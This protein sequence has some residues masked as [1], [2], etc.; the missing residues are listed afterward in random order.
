MGAMGGEVQGRS[1]GGEPGGPDRW[2]AR[3]G[4]RGEDDACPTPSLPLSLLLLI[5]VTSFLPPFP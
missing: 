3:C 1:D 4:G 5:H 2:A